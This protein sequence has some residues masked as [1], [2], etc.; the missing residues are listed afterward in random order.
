M[1]DRPDSE[2]PEARPRS[3]GDRGMRR[4]TL[5]ALIIGC[6]LDVIVIAAAIAGF[7]APAVVGALI[8]TALT[9]VVVVPTVLTAFLAPRMGPI[10]MA[11]TVLATWA[12]KM[13]VVVVVLIAIRDAQQVAFGWVGAALLAGALSAIAVEMIMLSRVRRPL[14]VA[15]PATAEDT[16]EEP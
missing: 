13:V 7:D 16:Q 4:A 11:V 3:A 15:E 2:R 10:R 1:S 14:D 12:G 9:L 5:T 8:G 6:G